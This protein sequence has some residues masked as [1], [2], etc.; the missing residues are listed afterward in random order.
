MVLDVLGPVETR[1]RKTVRASHMLPRPRGGVPADPPARVGA[2]PAAG[3]AQ[4]R[5]GTKRRM[6]CR[7]SSRCGGA[8]ARGLPG[9]R[10]R[11]APRRPARG[12]RRP[13]AVHLDRRTASRSV[14][15]CQPSSPSEHPM[16][17]LLQGEVGSGKTVVALAGDARLSS[18]PVGRPRCWP[19]PRSLRSSTSRSITELLGPL[20]ERGHARRC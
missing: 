6:S 12:L 4:V 9:D 2:R 15:S 19:R 5:F 3:A 16:Q 14:R 8:A 11:R 17:R 1:C 10:P 18:T 7:S 13:A 20:A